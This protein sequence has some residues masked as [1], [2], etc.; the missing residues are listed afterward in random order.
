MASIFIPLMAGE[1]GSKCMKELAQDMQG[2]CELEADVFVPNEFKAILNKK[3]RDVAADM[4]KYD[5]I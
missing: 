3:L 5:Y 1:V 4:V 2:D